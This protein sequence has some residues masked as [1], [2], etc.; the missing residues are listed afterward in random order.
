[1]KRAN[2]KVRIAQKTKDKVATR[3]RL[4]DTAEPSEP[5]ILEKPKIKDSSVEL[6][7]NQCCVCFGAFDEDLGTGRE[8]LQCSCTRWLQEGCVEEV[9]V[10]SSG[11]ERGCP[12]CLS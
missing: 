10:D 2:N 6:N 8:W 7:H 1:M 3:K 11:Q 12:L 9:V 4:S 5:P